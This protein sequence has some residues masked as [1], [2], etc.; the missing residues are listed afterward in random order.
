MVDDAY[1]ESGGKIVMGGN[2]SLEAWAGEMRIYLGLGSTGSISISRLKFTYKR[3]TT[4]GSP[5]VQIVHDGGTWEW[6]YDDVPVNSIYAKEVFFDP[7]LVV[8]HPTNPFT[9]P[10]GEV[11]NRRNCFTAFWSGKP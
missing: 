6:V 5:K 11:L 4:V 2:A 10:V 8:T 1:W 7:V 3:S 9:R